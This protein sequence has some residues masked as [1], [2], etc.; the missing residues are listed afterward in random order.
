MTAVDITSAAALLLDGRRCSAPPEL[1]AAM[2]T[3]EARYGGL[4]Y[5]LIVGS[6]MEYGLDGDVTG[7]PT[8]YG[9]AFAGILD[10][11]WT[12]GVDVLADGR[13]AMGPGAWPA[14]ERRKRPVRARGAFRQRLRRHPARV[15]HRGRSECFTAPGTPPVVREG[16]LPPPMPEATGPADRWWFDEVTAVQVMLH[17]WPPGHDHWIARVFARDA[18]L[19]AGEDSLIRSAVHEGRARAAGWC[20]LCSRGLPGAAV[21][22]P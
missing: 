13:T 22:L 5:P 17:G 3:F 20:E 11:D 1:V 2:R 14:A 4:G 12:C 16:L 18:E 8:L 9:L 7:Y 10:G 15:R 6:A 19:L 21:C